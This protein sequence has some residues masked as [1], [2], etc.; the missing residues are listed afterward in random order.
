[1]SAR[2]SAAA[3]P[4][5]NSSD[6]QAAGQAGTRASARRQSRVETPKQA[7]PQKPSAFAGGRLWWHFVLD[8]AVLAILLGVAVLGFGPTFGH[9]PAYLV[10][11]I[12]AIVL[13]LGVAAMGAHWRFGLIPLVGVGFLV[14]MLFGSALAAPNE[15]FLG[16]LPSLDSLRGLLLGIMLSWKQLLTLAPPVGTS[17]EVMVVPYLCAFV[18]AVVAGS[19]AWRLRTAYWALVPV[20]ALFITA[21]L[22]GTAEVFLPVLR[23][24]LLTVGAIAW[25]AY[26]HELVR[27][28]MAGS[29]SANQQ[30]QD[31]AGARASL[32]RRI[33]MGAGVILVAGALTMAAA[34]V[35]TQSSSREVLRDTVIPPPDLHA[36]PSPLTKFRD[37][38][39]NEKDTVLFTVEGM[40][41]NGRVRIAAMD[42]YD[43]VVFT[44][45]PNSSASFS[46]IGD[47][48]ALNQ[49]TDGEGR[50]VG[51]V[52]EGYQGVW[53]PNVAVARSLSYQSAQGSTP[54]LY[55]NKESGTALNLTGV[56]DG[57][58]YSMDV[59]FPQ[60]EGNKLAGSEFGRVNLPKLEN[61]PQVV[62][63]KANEIVGEADTPLKKVQALESALQRE[64]KFSNGLDGQAQSNSG[65]SAARITK[66]LSGK[67]MVGDDEQYA[68]VMVLM[69]RH[70][71]I[72]ARVVMGF[73]LDEKDTGNGAS[74]IKVKG[75]DVHAWVEVNFAG[76]GWVPFNPT[77]DKDNVPNPPEP[78]NASKPKPQV[79]QPPPPPQE[80]ADLPPDSAPDALDTDGK[81][82]QL[83]G[84]WGTILLIAGVAAIPLLIIALPLILIVVLKSRRRKKRLTT[85]LPTDRVGGGWSE[86]LSLATDLGAGPEPSGTRR[87]SA[88]AL[89]GAFPA[90]AGTTAL[91]AERADAAIFGPGQPSEE[92]VA[93]YWQNVEHSAQ[94]MTGSVGFWKR[95]RAKFSP[96]SLLADARLRAQ[97]RART[98]AQSKEADRGLWGG[99]SGDDQ[100][101]AGIRA[102][103]AQM[104]KKS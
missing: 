102:K 24:S 21:I 49:G 35:L 44:V 43:G 48:K 87:E 84:I 92:E 45:D 53:I 8:G 100:G 19:L 74:T 40:P 79:L 3:Q 26:R 104:M 34:P 20:V 62:G 18:T 81:K 91:L 46:P 90:T 78:Q 31:A 76:Q 97:E 22:F 23:G 88:A 70:L 5:N 67:E 47:P 29:I 68:T 13:G 36:L 94:G 37:Y 80:P 69:A 101:R 17:V 16:F 61:V 57:D 95:Q 83:A 41:K 59:Q 11:G 77:P 73:Y 60:V 93:T 15:A 54:T 39:K 32:L 63:T 75:A 33:G 55:L 12:G 98:K 65:H 7:L 85:G 103:L 1:M 50:D 25:L 30:V 9:S 89:Y 82:D 28:E 64:G 42:N 86:V 14:Y 10:A 96:R 99:E 52:I 72:P 6:S 51:L 56:K 4:Q 27:R 2:R 71:G 38:V 58:S 66:L